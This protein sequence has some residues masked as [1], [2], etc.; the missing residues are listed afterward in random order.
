MGGASSWEISFLLLTFI[1]EI[2]LESVG[3]DSRFD[4]IA[5]H[6]HFRDPKNR[7]QDGF[8]KVVI[9]PI[10]MEMGAGKSEA[11]P[12][13]GPFNG[14]HDRSEEHTS[15]LQSRFGISY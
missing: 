9:G 6:V 10:L 7:I 13:I 8:A 11:A 1:I 4:A 3:R 2:Q 5:G 12:A 15:E 14:P